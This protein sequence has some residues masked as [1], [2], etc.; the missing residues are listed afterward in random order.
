MPATFVLVH[1]AWHGGWCYTRVAQLLRASGASVF[2]PT[3]T[4]L[5]E[6]AH[7][8][9]PMIDLSTHVT[10]IVNV[11]RYED[12]H[13]VVL[14]GHSYGGLVITG[15]VERLPER[16]AALVFLDAFVPQDG[17]SL[18]DLVPASHRERQLEAAAAN[19]GFV[20]PIPAAVFGVNER[21]QAYVDAH[22]VPQPLPTFREGLALTGA[23]ERVAHKTYLRAGNYR[24]H[25]FD[26]ARERLTGEPGWVVETIPSGHDV[27]LDA[28]EALA[29]ALL[30]A[31]QRAG[32]TGS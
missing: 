22:C 16:V 32:L 18:Q 15:V 29:A 8:A 2:T 10:D 9:H 31:A 30:A 20:P 19:G 11:V 14:C 13:D 12:L 1:G 17:E 25:P 3:L 7:L 21:D 4:G 5:G 28:P 26:A 27:M 24:S 6:R 23:R